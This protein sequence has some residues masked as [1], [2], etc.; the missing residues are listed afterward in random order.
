MPLKKI[1]VVETAYLPG[2]DVVIWGVN[3]EDGKSHEIFWERKYF[4]TSFKEIK[5]EIPPK[6]VM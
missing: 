4:H 6:M 1:T 5:Q 3:T 2:N